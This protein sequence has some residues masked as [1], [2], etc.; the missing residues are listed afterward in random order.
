MNKLITVTQASA[1]LGIS[2]RR[3]QV[4]I[5]TKRLAAQIFGRTYAIDPE[6]VLRLDRRASGRPRKK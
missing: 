1:L 2:P 4:L 6:D 3:V 5:K